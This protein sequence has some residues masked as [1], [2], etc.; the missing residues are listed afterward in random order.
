[1]KALHA[2]ALSLLAA[3]AAGGVRA[4]EPTPAE[5]AAARVHAQDIADLFREACLQQLADPGA[6]AGWALSHGFAS[7]THTRAGREVAEAMKERGETGHVFFR[8][9]DESMLLIPTADPSNCVVMGLSV[10]DGP[11]LRGRMEALSGEWPGVVVTP[12][13]ATSMDY[14]QKVPHRVLRYTGVTGQIRYRLTA[15]SPIGTARGSVI[16]GVLVEPGR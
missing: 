7:A 1:M 15:V 2:I 14:D 4:A 3:C 16:L 6:V 8:P 11:R 10:V 13:P 5:R 9:G 12:E